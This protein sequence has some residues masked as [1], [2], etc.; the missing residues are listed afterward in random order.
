MRPSAPRGILLTG[1]TGYLG[2]LVAATLLTQDDVTLLVPVR[3][4]YD[5]EGFWGPV[6]V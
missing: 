5:A 6:R 4:Q 2:G 3:A 1:G